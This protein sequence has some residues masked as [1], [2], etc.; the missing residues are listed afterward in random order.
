MK[1]IITLLFI[2]SLPLMADIQRPPDNF[3]IGIDVFDFSLENVQEITLSD[4][5]VIT[6]KQIQ[7]FIQTRTAK[8]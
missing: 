3:D 4:G 8:N 1:Y 6:K 5:T 7:E 2:A